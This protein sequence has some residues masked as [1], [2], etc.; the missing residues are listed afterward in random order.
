[1]EFL[2]K[3]HVA[4]PDLPKLKKFR[5]PES[6]PFYNKSLTKKQIFHQLVWGSTL[7]PQFSIPLMHF[8]NSCC[9]NRFTSAG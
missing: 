7:K 9:Q 4:D 2:I 8:A 1:M 6:L 5:S 3:K